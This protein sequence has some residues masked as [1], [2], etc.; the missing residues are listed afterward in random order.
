MGF[1]GMGCFFCVFFLLLGEKVVVVVVV[2]RSMMTKIYLVISWAK[3]IKF[4]MIHAMPN[5]L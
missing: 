4:M 1:Q 3:T 5:L 2:G